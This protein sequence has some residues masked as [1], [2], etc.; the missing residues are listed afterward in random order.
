M[1][2][3]EL[4]ETCLFD[5]I[6]TED[7]TGRF[8]RLYGAGDY[9]H[10][11]EESAYQL[12]Q[13][14]VTHDVTVL[15]HKVYPFPVLMVSISDDELQAYGKNHIF[16]KK[17][18][19]YRELVGIGISMKRYKECVIVKTCSD[20]FYTIGQKKCPMPSAKIRNYSHS[21]NLVSQ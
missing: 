4:I 21:H 10:A 18:S 12:S 2:L 14:F 19:G 6:H 8:I 3:M 11:F 16:R 9:W 15:R 20:I 17:V 7:T 5:I 13:L 1:P